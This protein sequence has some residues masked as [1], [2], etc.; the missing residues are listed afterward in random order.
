MKANCASWDCGW[1]ILSITS[2]EG[3]GT[4]FCWSKGILYAK[5]ALFLNSLLLHPCLWNHIKTRRNELSSSYWNLILALDLVLVDEQS[6]KGS[7]SYQLEYMVSNIVTSHHTSFWYLF[8]TPHTESR[9][10]FL[11]QNPCLEHACYDNY[12]LFPKDKG[13]HHLWVLFHHHEHCLWYISFS[14][15]IINSF[16]GTWFKILFVSLHVWGKS[17][18]KKNMLNNK[19]TKIKLLHNMLLLLFQVSIIIKSKCS[20][21]ASKNPTNIITNNN[22]Y[23]HMKHNHHECQHQECIHK[24][25]ISHFE[26]RSENKYQYL[27]RWR[28]DIHCKWEIIDLDC[29]AILVYLWWSFYW[30]LQWKQ[31]SFSISPLFVWRFA[32][33]ERTAVVGT[34]ALFD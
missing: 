34:F 27:A 10:F 5:V 18:I 26:I 25:Q 14:I 16:T 3:C 8:L 15:L 20:T 7:P 9:V 32:M 12:E 4:L 28:L 6:L 33:K 23:T 22:Q 17:F 19:H 29:Y 31:W 1:F 24:S 2:L 30:D 13:Y 21:P 11:Y